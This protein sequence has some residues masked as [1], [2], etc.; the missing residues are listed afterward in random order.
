[1]ILLFRK[2]LK[3]VYLIISFFFVILFFTNSQFIKTFSHL[4]ITSAYFTLIIAIYSIISVLNFGL[5]KL[6]ASKIPK[7]NKETLNLSPH[8]LKYY[9]INKPWLKKNNEQIYPIKS[10]LLSTLSSKELSYKGIISL[11]FITCF[12][13]ILMFSPL[14]LILGYKLNIPIDLVNIYFSLSFFDLGTGLITR[15][16]NSKSLHE[17]LKTHKTLFIR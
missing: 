14:K 4:D 5:P 2:I 9:W 1:M 3:I 10:F 11:L 8:E 6:F 17:F 16:T 12:S 13:Y 15:F 7:Q